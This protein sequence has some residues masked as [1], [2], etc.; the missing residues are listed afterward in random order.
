MQYAGLLAT[1]FGVLA[2]R[3]VFHVFATPKGH[4][5]RGLHVFSACMFT[6]L[7]LVVAYGGHYLFSR[8]YTLEAIVPIYDG[9][10]Y[11]PERNALFPNDVWVF[12]TT[13]SPAQIIEFYRTIASGT[14]RTL[15]QHDSASS[16]ELLLPSTEEMF[17]TIKEE[18]PLSVLYYSR[19]GEMRT[20]N[21]KLIPR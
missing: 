8:T 16:T 18:P 9:A 7:A 13:G 21:T 6:L 14:R 19:K 2:L 15:I 5:D 3:A 12:T 17:L 10:R 11:V 1:L 4:P 20:V